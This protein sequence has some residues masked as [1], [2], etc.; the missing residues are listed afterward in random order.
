MKAVF[1]K[2]AQQ[3]R[4]HLNQQETNKQKIESRLGAL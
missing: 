1:T 4:T 3:L 2:I